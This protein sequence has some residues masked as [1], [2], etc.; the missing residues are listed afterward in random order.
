M[1]SRTPE[2]RS[3]TQRPRMHAGK[4]GSRLSP[5]S[6]GMTKHVCD[7]QRTRG[8]LRSLQSLPDL[9]RA[10]RRRG[11]QQAEISLRGDEAHAL[12]DERELALEV[13]LAAEAGVFAVRLGGGDHALDRCYH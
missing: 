8:C 13:A 1:S 2:G 3:G 12:A 10:L 5:R 4:D 9:L 7:A 6:A 11:H